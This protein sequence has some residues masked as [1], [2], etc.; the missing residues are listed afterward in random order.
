MK[1]PSVLA[2]EAYPSDLTDKQFARVRPLPEA[3]R[4]KTRPLK[5][6]LL[7]V[8]NAILCVLKG[9]NS[10]RSLPHDCPSWS[11]VY[12]HFRVWR[13]HVDKESGLPLLELALKKIDFRGAAQNRARGGADPACP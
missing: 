12:Y 5:A 3:A 7:D 4:R 6:D 8:F 10:W 9:G 1:T 13:D 2:R 11:I